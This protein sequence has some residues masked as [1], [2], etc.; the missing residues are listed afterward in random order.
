MGEHE[1]QGQDDLPPRA[2]GLPW[3]SKHLRAAQLRALGHK[4]TQVAEHLEQNA[5]AIRNYALIEGFDALIRHYSEK[6]FDADV[7][8]RFLSGSL[9]AL[10]VLQA[11]WRHELDTQDRI[12][13]QLA[14]GMIDGDL[15]DDEVKGLMRAL[16]FS[17][18]HATMA[19]DKYLAAI[20]FSKA[21]A[22]REE[23]RVE[24]AVQGH[25]GT[26]VK[27]ERDAD[28]ELDRTA[29]I[30]AAVQAASRATAP[31]RADDPEDL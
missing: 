9:E 10:D 15:A 21:R 14:H 23:M 2:D 12:K 7:E 27:V 18:K 22:R 24:K 25:T 30:M 19:A 28:E 13:E 11:Q 26:R 29:E 31:D 17:T 16:D 6:A 1:T 20:G 3:S 8:A 5:S 4:W